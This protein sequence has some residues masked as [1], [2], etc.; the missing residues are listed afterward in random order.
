MIYQSVVTLS[1]LFMLLLPLRTFCLPNDIMGSMN[2]AENLHTR[3]NI[4]GINI[5]LILKLSNEKR[6]FMLNLSH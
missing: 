1:D 2:A 5:P 4:Y 6:P 3:E